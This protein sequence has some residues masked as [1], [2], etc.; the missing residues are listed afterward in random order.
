MLAKKL[1]SLP[2][3]MSYPPLYVASR[4]T[5]VS[6]LVE[7]WIPKLVKNVNNK[8]SL[9]NSSNRNGEHLT[10]FTQENRLTCLHTK[11]QKRKGKLSTYTNAKNTK[12]QIDY[13][14]IN[15]K[16]NNSALNYEAFSS[17]EGVS[18][19][20]RFVTAKIRLRMRATTTVHYDWSRLTTGILEINIRKH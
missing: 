17:F 5:T 20:H 16:W 14:F 2:S 13:V 8:F 9:H 6:S 12:A 1:T 19:D 7:T 11:F 18:S 15:K 4:N 10:Y 3:I